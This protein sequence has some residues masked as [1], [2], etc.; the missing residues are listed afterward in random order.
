[1]HHTGRGKWQCFASHAQRDLALDF[2]RLLIATCSY[3]SV[4][5]YKAEIKVTYADAMEDQNKSKLFIQIYPNPK[6]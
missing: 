4:F 3:L 6:S 2:H 5:L 1:M